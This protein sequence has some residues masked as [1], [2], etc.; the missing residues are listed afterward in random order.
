MAAVQTTIDRPLFREQLLHS[1]HQFLPPSEF[2]RAGD[3]QSISQLPSSSNLTRYLASMHQKVPHRLRLLAGYMSDDNIVFLDAYS[4]SVVVVKGL[5]K[6][7]KDLSQT[8]S[9]NR[10]VDMMP[11]N[12]ALET[13]RS[14]NLA[15]HLHATRLLRR[16]GRLHPP[17]MSMRISAYCP[18][19]A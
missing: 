14:F 8:R 7:H 3:L 19:S 10:L 16:C 17:I 15:R 1:V 6:Y 11:T 5:R 2:V 12:N 18:I 9:P 4:V 13:V